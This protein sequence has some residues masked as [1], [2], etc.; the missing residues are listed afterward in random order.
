[1]PFLGQKEDQGL[2]CV[3]ADIETRAYECVFVCEVRDRLTGVSH[4]QDEDNEDEDKDDGT[5]G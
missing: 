3:E 5:V 1:M 4:R 2:V